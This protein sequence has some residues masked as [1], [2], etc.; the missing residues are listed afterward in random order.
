[1]ATITLDLV[2]LKCP[3]PVLHT[4]KALARLRRGD[5]LQ[6]LCT[7]PM[8]AIDIPVLAKSL[9][10]TVTATSDDEDGLRFVIEKIDN[11]V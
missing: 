7:D 9:G 11:G 6:V 8:A 1:M 5:R 3:L 2:G 10:Y 4:R